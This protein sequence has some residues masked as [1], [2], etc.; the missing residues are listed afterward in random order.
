[1]MWKIEIEEQ[2]LKSIKIKVV[3]T[4]IKTNKTFLKKSELEI[5]SED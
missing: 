5:G 2:F 1:M 4:L 3:F